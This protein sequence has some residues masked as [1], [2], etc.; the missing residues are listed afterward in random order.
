MLDRH[1]LLRYRTVVI[2]VGGNGEVGIAVV[3]NVLMQVFGLH[4]LDVTLARNGC[5]RC[6]P[7]VL[8]NEIFLETIPLGTAQGT[9][10]SKSLM[11]HGSKATPRTPNVL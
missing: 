9:A 8:S 3:P 2:D 1:G 6:A 11:D 7:T 10:L 5:V 4:E